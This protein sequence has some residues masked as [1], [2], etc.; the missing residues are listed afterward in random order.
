MYG[1]GKGEGP[2][3]HTALLMGARR[4]PPTHPHGPPGASLPTR[5]LCIPGSSS[6]AMAAPSRC[7]RGGGRWDRV[8][9][10]PGQGVHGRG[11]HAP[12]SVTGHLRLQAPSKP[13]WD[14]GRAQSLEARGGGGA[15]V[16]AVLLQSLCGRGLPVPSIKQLR[17][18]CTIQMCA[19]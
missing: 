12:P 8:P 15:G 19:K 11:P 4:G 6:I 2:W 9:A 1:E 16:G 7:G 5:R 18:M 13:P 14:G 17:Q 10:S 3:C